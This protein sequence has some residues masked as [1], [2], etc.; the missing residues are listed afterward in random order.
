MPSLKAL[1]MFKIRLLSMAD[2]ECKLIDVDKNAVN[3]AKRNKHSRFE[4]YFKSDVTKIL[5][6]TT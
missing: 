4:N 3:E 6:R 2:R 5:N 1:L